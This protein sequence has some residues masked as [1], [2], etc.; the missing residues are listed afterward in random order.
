MSYT[1]T[2]LLTGGTGDL[3]YYAAINI[4]QKYPKYLVIITGRSDPKST[5]KKIN[6]QLRQQNVTFLPLDLST[7]AT[8][9]LPD[10]IYYSAE[11]LAH[12]DPATAY[13]K[14]IQRYNTSKLTNILWAY[15]LSRHLQDAKSSITV[16]AF[17]PGLMFGTGL[18]RDYTLVF[19]FMWFHVF[20][21]IGPLVK[22]I[23]PTVRNV[24]ESGAELAWVAL[25]SE[26]AGI[27]GKYF[28]GKKDTTS[29]AA[30]YDV[31]KQE[32]LWQWT[33]REIL[34]K[35]CLR[36]AAELT[37]KGGFNVIL[38]SAQGE[39]LHS[40][41]QVLATLGHIM[42]NASYCSVDPLI[43]LDSDPLLGQELMQAVDGY[44]RKG[45][46]RPIP[47]ITAP[48]VAQLSQVL[49]NFSAMIGQLVVTFTNPE[50]LVRMISATPT[51]SFDHEA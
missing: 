17:N 25:S 21:H 16:N 22:F 18:G 44:Y 12:P 48:D 41:L 10:A 3:G 20:P 7:T 51:A 15:A 47:K 14:G 32:D 13:P 4:A 45:H 49:G 42:D 6:T 28:D 33:D 8:S 37:P 19:R 26:T 43:I 29:S 23:M 39:L 5:A 46:I 9:G 1:S 38:S 11:Q 30:S 34:N 50:S 2:V 24:K 36:K 27:T 40:S 31:A 35:D